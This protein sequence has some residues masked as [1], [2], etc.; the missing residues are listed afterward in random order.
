MLGEG[1]LRVLC[2]REERKAASAAKLRNQTH[3]L[4][5]DP[6]HGVPSYSHSEQLALPSK[7]AGPNTALE[8]A[9]ARSLEPCGASRPV[10][11]L[12][13]SGC[14]SGLGHDHNVCSLLQH[15]P[16]LR[17]GKESGESD[18]S[19]SPV[20]ASVPGRRASALIPTCGVP[21]IMVHVDSREPQQKPGI[22]V[23]DQGYLVIGAS[24]NTSLDLPG[25]GLLEPMSNSLLNGLLEKQLEEVY[26]Q[27]LTESLARC[28]SQPGHSLLRE[29]VPPLQR[30]CPPAGPLDSLEVALQG[31]MLGLGLG[32]Q[33]IS[34]LNT[35]NMEEAQSSHFS[36]PVLRISDAE[37]AYH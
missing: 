35:Q 36:S 37:N 5:E 12:S 13:V 7:P 21:H 16:D 2:Y 30:N 32:S 22:S 14:P 27:H 1:F 19:S 29:L 18:D 4:C 33:E 17:L 6:D 15:Y 3:S 25:Q 11:G 24:V 10:A 31:G 34:Y 8:L 26:L 28:D 9:G 20:R 23:P